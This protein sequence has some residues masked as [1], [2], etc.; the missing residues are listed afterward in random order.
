M[1]FSRESPQHYGTGHFTDRRDKLIG[2]DAL[3]GVPRSRYAGF[4]MFVLAKD[5]RLMAT[6]SRAPLVIPRLPLL[7]E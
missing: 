2:A 4:S 1:T 7:E 5:R 6:N 3:P